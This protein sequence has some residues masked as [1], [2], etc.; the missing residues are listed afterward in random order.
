MIQSQIQLLDGIFE[1]ECVFYHVMKMKQFTPLCLLGSQNVFCCEHDVH[2]VRCIVGGGLDW[3]TTRHHDAAKLRPREFSTFSTEII[4]TINI[5]ANIK[6][7][8]LGQKNLI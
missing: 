7:I 4:C 3:E 1:M 8:K 6:V 2:G 5:V